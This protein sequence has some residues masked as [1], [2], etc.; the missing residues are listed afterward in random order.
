VSAELAAKRTA[1]E[2]L[3]EDFEM[4][5]DTEAINGGPPVTYAVSAGRPAIALRG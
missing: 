3:L 1:A 2:A 5:P 4:P